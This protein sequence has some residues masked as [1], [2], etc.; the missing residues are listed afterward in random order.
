MVEILT[1]AELKLIMLTDHD[2][3]ILLKLMFVSAWDYG[4][5]IT[6]GGYND[7]FTNLINLGF[8]D[9][10][11]TPDRDWYEYKPTKLF[12]WLKKQLTK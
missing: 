4:Y 5:G 6:G 8:I 11:K 1:K 7:N 3:E 9:E 10:T 12:G 2:K